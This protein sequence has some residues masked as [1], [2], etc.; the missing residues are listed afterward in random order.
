IEKLGIKVY[1]LNLNKKNIFKSFKKS[2][3][4]S[5]DSDVINT[6]LYH[7]DIFGFIVA[8]ILLKKKLIWN[9]RHRNLD[10][11][12]NKARTL[13]IVKLNSFLS[14]YVDTITY[15]SNKALETHADFGYKGRNSVVIPNGFELDEFQF[16][17]EDR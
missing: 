10:K 6:W 16:N 8:K 3:K 7:A 14:K 15:N 13:K 11:N 17:S 2:R 5:K 9:V 1:P 12:A 4:I